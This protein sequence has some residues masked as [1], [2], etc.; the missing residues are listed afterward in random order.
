MSVHIRMFQGVPLIHHLVLTRVSTS[1]LTSIFIC[2]FYVLFKQ[3]PHWS[4]LVNVVLLRLEL[5]LVWWTDSNVDWVP[6]LDL[7]LI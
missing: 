1:I 6:Y 5:Y 4:V 3:R 2:L 7:T